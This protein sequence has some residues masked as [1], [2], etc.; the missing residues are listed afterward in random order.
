MYITTQITQNKLV[1]ASEDH[2]VCVWYYKKTKSMSK[3][4]VCVCVCSIIIV[5]VTLRHYLY[6]L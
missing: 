6:Q 5:C 2:T 4:C 1:S 3:V